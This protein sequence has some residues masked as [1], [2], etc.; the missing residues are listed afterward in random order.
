[1]LA[2]DSEE[3][4]EEQ[5]MIADT[6]SIPPGGTS[7]RLVL[8][9]IA[10]ALIVAFC[11][12]GG[13]FVDQ[14]PDEAHLVDGKL[15]DEERRAMCGPSLENGQLVVVNMIYSDDKTTWIREATTLFT[16]KC[17]N[18]AIRA[19]AIA[20]IEAADG[21]AEGRLSTLAWSPAGD[22]AAR[23]LHQRQR[24]MGQ[25]NLLNVH[26]SISLVKSPI[27]FLMWEDRLHVGVDMVARL[28]TREGGWKETLCPLVPRDTPH[29]ELM[30][31]EEKVPGT[32]ID[33]YKFAHASPPPKLLPGQPEKNVVPNIEYVRPM[34]TLDDLR[35]WGRV[36]FVH[37]SPTHSAAGL[38]V[39]YLMMYDYVL[40]PYERRSELAE[41]IA[42]SRAHRSKVPLVVRG[43]IVAEDLQHAFEKK[44]DS[45][46]RWLERCEA[47]L[48][49]APKSAKL[50]TE[51]LI[52]VGPSRYD[53]VITYEHYVFSIFAALDEH[54]L[55]LP[56][57]RVIYPEPTLLNEHPVYY[58]DHADTTEEEKEARSRWIAFLRSPE[59]QLLA[60]SHGFRP[61][62][63]EVNVRSEGPEHN[64]FMNARRYGVNFEVPIIEPPRLGGDVV[65]DLINLWKDATGRN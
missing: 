18:V 11:A 13:N 59:T 15:F 60:I 28:A 63:P 38:D 35:S 21:I 40:P 27:V 45:L 16:R 2:H 37:T 43:D 48:A 7:W 41:Q 61:S 20:D 64:P 54:A 26:E 58:F 6:D 56:D 9:V 53:G 34:P 19:T 4:I 5:C 10:L 32:W 22:L 33:L 44:R 42:K 65:K 30:P 14:L 31:L 50:L 3:P 8:G 62:N 57:V 29:L 39:L 23:Y 55:D 24:E 17:P 47:G 1:M 25:K 12:R 51:D 49:P 36:K 52:N 46:R